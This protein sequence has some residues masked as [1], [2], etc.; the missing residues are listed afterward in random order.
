MISYLQ[1]RYALSEVGAK[2]MRMGILQS[3]LVD[4]ASFL[5]SGLLFFFLRRVLTLYWEGAG[6]LPS[7]RF[8]LL[9]S[10]VSFL[11]LWG[12]CYLQY[13]AVYMRVY[14]ESARMRLTLAERLR[15]L[16]LAYFAKRDVA[17]FS[18]TI[19]GDLTLVESLFS[20]ATPQM[21]AA[22]MSYGISF[23][24]LP[25]F[26]FKMALA[27]LWPFPLAALIFFS[28]RAYMKRMAEHVFA[29]QRFCLDLSQEQLEMVQEIKAYNSERRFGHDY[30]A[31]LDRY[32]SQL[33][34]FELFGGVLI[35]FAGLFIR[36]APASAAFF[37]SLMYLKG[38][39]ELLPFLVFLL[40][41]DP[42]YQPLL[43]ALNH[44]AAQVVLETKIERLKEIK[45]LPLQEGREDFEPQHYDISFE[46]VSFA[47]EDTPTLKNISFTA[48][49]GEVTALVGPSGGGKSTVSRLAAR[50]WDASSGQVRMGGV[51][52]SEID[53][54]TLLK[55][56]AIV[57]QEVILFN[58]SI[59]ENIR[60]GRSDASDEEVIQAAKHAQCDDFVQKLPE[61]YQTEI[62]ENGARLSGG[63]RQRISIARAILKDAPIILLDEATASLD[64]ENESRIQAA[65]SQLIKNKT[66]LV[67]AHRMR[68]VANAD[69]VIVLEEGE[70]IEQGP[71][72][73]LRE[74][75]GYFARM[76]KQGQ[77]LEA[78]SA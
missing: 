22:F 30:E 57:F 47:Y 25:F 51:D 10:L 60:L 2:N 50:F 29:Q 15:L 45:E 73:H 69:K 1:G 40:I 27:I 13:D 41:T 3:F 68:T 61:G 75:D 19:M 77:T 65:L 4:L 58:D 37:G 11:I 24:I 5:P 76:F 6:Q 54:E 35:S 42:L 18:A 20:H 21:Y 78:P 59:L 53:P 17:D 23:L 14:L 28:A 8:V 16:P 39:V 63:E 72:K 26:H 7:L 62:G 33:I 48:K 46:K 55:S 44:M 74:E 64:A 66:V 31:S 71:A 32:E 34:R 70:I 12:I 52:L 49:Q 38:Q 9:Y 43:A 36:L 56:Y 67:I